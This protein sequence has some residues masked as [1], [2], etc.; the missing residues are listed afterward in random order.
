MRNTKKH[1]DSKH[2]NLESQ[3]PER[4]SMANGDTLIDKGEN[5]MSA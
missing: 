2:R 1:R 3:V 5:K 4:I